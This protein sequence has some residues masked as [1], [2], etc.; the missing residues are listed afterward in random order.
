MENS[1]TAQHQ[2]SDSTPYLLPISEFSE[3]FGIDPDLF[4]LAAISNG[5]WWVKKPTQ[6]IRATEALRIL[7]WIQQCGL[8]QFVVASTTESVTHSQATP[9]TCPHL[10]A[11]IAR[12]HKLIDENFDRIRGLKWKWAVGEILELLYKSPASMRVV[13]KR[14]I[15]LQA[16]EQAIETHPR[17]RVARTSDLPFVATVVG[18]LKRLH[19]GRLAWLWVDDA[20]NGLSYLVDQSRKTTERTVH[21]RETAEFSPGE[22]VWVALEET[23]NGRRSRKRHPALLLSLTGKRNDK[24]LLVSLTTDVDEKRELRKV[25]DPEDLGLPYGGYVWHEAQKVYHTQIEN[26]IGWVTRSLIEVVDRTINLR[27]S[28]TEDLLHIADAH[29]RESEAA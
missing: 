20:E 23:S 28:M 29:H 6:Q 14:G 8:T 19:K 1:Q 12:F 24:W 5:C 2:E 21:E 26:H 27:Q 9:I 18:E 10:S 7:E 16:L 4:A 25:Q 22:I 3:S 15:S 17:L 11:D 13:K